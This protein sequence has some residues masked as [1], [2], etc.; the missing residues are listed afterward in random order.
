MTELGDALNAVGNPSTNIGDALT[1][2]GDPAAD[3]SE[4]LRSVQGSGEELQWVRL[5]GGSFDGRNVQAQ[6]PHH[7][8]RVG[9][10]NGDDGVWTE[11]YLYVINGTTEDPELGTIPVMRFQ[12]RGEVDREASP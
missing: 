8:L 9:V 10:R 7:A 1:A 5:Q 6:L 2:L 4:A 12:S 3:M 11:L